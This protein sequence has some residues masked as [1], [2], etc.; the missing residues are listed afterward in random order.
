VSIRKN[1]AIV[2]AIV[3]VLAGS[4]HAYVCGDLN[5]N[6]GISAPDALAALRFSVGLNVSIDC[7]PQH[8]T[9]V[10]GLTQCSNNEGDF[11][12]CE[13][14]GQDGELQK[15]AP[16]AF[17]DNGNG[18]V[19]DRATGLVWEQLDDAGG[20]H[21]REHKLDQT[22]GYAKI[23]EL[24]AASFA[25]HSDWRLPNVF[26]QMSLGDF[27]GYQTGLY[28][29]YFNHD[30]VPG[31]AIPDCACVTQPSYEWS[32]TSY[33]ADPSIA[34]A[35]RTIIGDPI[36]QNKDL[37]NY[38]ARAVRG[39][40]SASDVSSEPAFANSCADVNGSDT[41]TTG[42]A[43]AILRKAVGLSVNLRC[44]LRS[45]T[46]T[47]GQPDCFDAA[48]LGI[49]CAGTGQDGELQK[50]VSRSFK[51]NGD[52]TVTDEITG[53]VW[54]LLSSDGSVHDASNDYTWIEAQTK[55]A[56]LNDSSF[57]GHSDWRV[58][59]F[60]ELQSL[61]YLGDPNTAAYNAFFNFGC[62]PQ[63]APP[64]CS[65]PPSTESVWSSSMPLNNKEY[66]YKTN[67]VSGRADWELKTVGLN[68]R[69]VRGG[70]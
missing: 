35:F 38:T 11:I 28:I 40:Y 13:G 60:F 66:A 24:N 30:C 58:P 25:G 48:G 31:C 64:Q 7:G 6:Q 16:R 17:E 70:D 42:D 50:G 56:E 5:G 51:N 55:I 26:E 67:F 41:I 33:R 57:A 12:D 47:T 61:L 62:A 69:G 15:G 49:P 37:A 22:G 53:L 54:E 8:R 9:L 3:G 68:V 29:P 18:T 36:I 1:I 44:I 27:G 65:C 2:S 14:T 32:S 63:C 39:G 23:A 20:I 45:T 21:D 19:T 52:G 4:A 46:L 43:L 59:N 34:F 10:T